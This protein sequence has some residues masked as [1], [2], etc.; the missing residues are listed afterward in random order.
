MCGSFKLTSD[1]RRT[2]SLYKIP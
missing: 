2:L 1:T